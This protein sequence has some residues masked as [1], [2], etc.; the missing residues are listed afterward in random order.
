MRMLFST[1]PRSLKT[2]KNLRFESVKN[3]KKRRVM[4]MDEQGMVVIWKKEQEQ[5][6]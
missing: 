2:V 3:W 1:P 5:E 6:A 4:H